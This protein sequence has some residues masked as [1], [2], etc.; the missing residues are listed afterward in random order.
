MSFKEIADI[1]YHALAFGAGLCVLYGVVKTSF[2]KHQEP[3]DEDQS[4]KE[5]ENYTAGETVEFKGDEVRINTLDN[6]VNY[7]PFSEKDYRAKGR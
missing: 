4:F 2:P 7:N 6:K 3:K 5:L 1:G